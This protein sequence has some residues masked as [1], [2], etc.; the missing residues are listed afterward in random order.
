MKEELNRPIGRPRHTKKPQNVQQNQQQ[1][2]KPSSSSSFHEKFHNLT[3]PENDT[4]ANDMRYSKLSGNF[5]DEEDD[6]DRT[7]DIV[8]AYETETEE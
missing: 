2:E 6:Y 7:A 8:P 3:D 5:N 1:L 4:S